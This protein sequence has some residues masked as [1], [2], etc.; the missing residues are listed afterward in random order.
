MRLLPLLLAV[1]Q[2]PHPQR[3]DLRAGLDTIYSGA[4]PAAAQYFET[5][6]AKDTSD[7]AP[8]I[9]QASAYIWWAEA[10]DSDDFEAPRIDSLLDAAIRHA[11]ADSTPTARFWLGTALGYRARE[12]DLRGS[13]LGAG[14]DAKAMRDAYATVLATD[15]TC[16][17]C[18][19][20]LGV[21]HYGL[22]RASA[23]SRLFAKIIGLGSGNADVGLADLRR[24]AERGD[25]AKVEAIWVLAAALEREAAR[26]KHQRQTLSAEAR[27]L[28]TG[29]AA[30]YPGNPV[31]ARFLAEVHAP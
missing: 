7:P 21:Y 16:E 1:L 13:A 5:L 27:A 6:A 18:Y 24:A 19:L 28:V 14:K 11:R 26:D 23:L 15:S 8:L 4:F 30:K 17:D 20:G 9:F 22:A 10:K 25:L 2:Q 31:F 29:L 3:P 12:R